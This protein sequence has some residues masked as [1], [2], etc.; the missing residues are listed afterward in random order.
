MKAKARFSP[1][2]IALVEEGWREIF[3]L[4]AAEMNL[5]HDPRLLVLEAGIPSDSTQS[6]RLSLA[7]A[8][9][10][11]VLAQIRQLTMDTTEYHYLKL[12]ALFKTTP[13]FFKKDFL[14]YSYYLFWRENRLFQS[15]EHVREVPERAEFRTSQAFPRM[16]PGGAFELRQQNANKPFS[17]LQP[18]NRADVHEHRERGKRTRTVLQNCCGGP[19]HD[20]QTD[21]RHLCERYI[22][23][24]D[25]NV[26]HQ[27]PRERT[28]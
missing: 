27:K 2:Q 7:A 11:S 25:E 13:D 21:S 4:G 14:Y 19:L 18:E 17:I 9:L 5:V 24:I 23:S 6:T 28:R 12:I 8:T 15:T 16:G 20:E 10:C 3:L 22:S 26:D 1:L